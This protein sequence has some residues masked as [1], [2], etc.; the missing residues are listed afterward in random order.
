[1]LAAVVAEAG[2]T[3]EPFQLLQPYINLEL[4]VQE[5]ITHFRQ[6]VTQVDPAVAVA[7]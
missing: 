6:L 7:V 4:L 2:M 1:L 3:L 5:E